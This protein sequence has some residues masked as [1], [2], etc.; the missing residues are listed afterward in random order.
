M[1]LPKKLQ[2]SPNPREEKINLVVDQQIIRETQSTFEGPPPAITRGPISSK[3]TLETI[4]EASSS[5]EKG[6]EPVTL[7]P[8]DEE[9]LPELE[10]SKPFTTADFGDEIPEVEEAMTRE[11]W[12][13]VQKHADEN[14]SL[15]RSPPFSFMDLESRHD[16]EADHA[17]QPEDARTMASTSK[18]TIRTLPS[19]QG[20][21]EGRSFTMLVPTM[22]KSL[23][24]ERDTTNLQALLSAPVTC[25]LP[26]SELL[27]IKPD[28]W[29][30]VAAC[31]TKQGVWEPWL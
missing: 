19:Y 26:L 18:V 14:E 22:R 23:S 17:L 20:E 9:P 12:E 21:Y 24:R 5:M 4:P 31:L 16:I 15:N 30:N 11:M 10:P 8:F 7:S 1:E 27:K 28:L 13:A 29:M 6:S 3:P 25:T 2:E